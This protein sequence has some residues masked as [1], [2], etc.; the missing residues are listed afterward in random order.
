[1]R[2]RQAGGPR[3]LRTV[4]FTDI[5][6]STEHAARDGDRAWGE[7]LARH[8]AVV[9]AALKATG[10]REMDT[11]GDGFFATFARPTDALAC[12]GRIVAGV[13]SLG[14]AVRVGIHA[15][16]VEIQEGKAAGIT[17]HTAARLMAAAGADE[18]LL[19]GTVRELAAGAG[20]TFADRGQL[21][22]RGLAEPVRA[23]ALDLAAA[24]P[25][26][27]MGRVG[28]GA[29]LA[30]RAGGRWPIGAAAVVVVAAVVLV[31]VSLAGAG[32]RPC[33]HA[34]ADHDGG[35]LGHAGRTTATQPDGGD[36]GVLQP[37]CRGLVPARDGV[38]GRIRPAP[39]HI[40]S[41]RT[42]H[43]PRPSRWMIPVGG[44]MATTTRCSSSRGRPAPPTRWR[45]YWLTTLATDPCAQNPETT[46]GPEPDKVFL[47]WARSNK[48]LS[49]D[50]EHVAAVREPG[51][52]RDRR[53]GGRQ[54]RL[55]V[56]GSDLGISDRLPAESGPR[57]RS[58]WLRPIT[59]A[60]RGLAF[61]SG[62]RTR[63]EVAAEDGKLLL[64]V[65]ETPTAAEFDSFR[66]LAEKIL[67]TLKF[68]P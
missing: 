33:R 57:Q 39:R 50:P 26:V 9:R 35:R 49:R 11:A 22:L 27:A 55:P 34:H 28:A 56:H 17:V 47:A 3:D 43:Q 32:G 42:S 16:E 6:G 30:E 38:H 52:D 40:R 1:M 21:E 4:L 25:T 19:S 20:W 29:L 41:R 5:V 37:L 2:G 61:T 62:T 64:T 53:V 23:Y 59:G 31:A 10:G 54:V 46:I 68:T 58:C 24:P 7:L 48:A 60:L 44:W 14:L 67:S 18:V 45:I 13:Q 36:V 65:L 63:V 12:A 66:P 15:G 8:H 51:D